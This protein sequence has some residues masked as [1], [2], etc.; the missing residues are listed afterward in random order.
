MPGV[1][2]LNDF[3]IAPNADPDIPLAA[4][5]A[6]AN[7]V[8]SGNLTPGSFPFNKSN[9]PPA[10]PGNLPAA[11]PNK[12]FAAPVKLPAAP[13]NAPAAPPA[14][15][16]RLLAAPVKLLATPPNAAPAA[17][18]TLLVRSAVAPDN[19]ALGFGIPAIPFVIDPN[20]PVTVDAIFE[21]KLPADIVPA[22][23]AKALGT[24]ISIKLLSLNQKHVNQLN[25]LN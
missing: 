14:P 16:N 6:P 19:N 23:L 5:S 21:A 1:N 15:P 24:G 8:I 12:L 22:T 17:P 20:P 10:P 25:L 4:S 11:A 13:A 7:P 18:V 3:V 2:D 9:A